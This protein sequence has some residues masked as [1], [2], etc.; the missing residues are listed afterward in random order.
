[1]RNGGR[2]AARVLLWSG[3]RRQECEADVCEECG[4]F[5]GPTAPT[6]TGSEPGTGDAWRRIVLTLAVLVPVLTRGSQPWRERT[7]GADA[8]RERPQVQPFGRSLAIVAHPRRPVVLA[9]L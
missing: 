6:M 7:V 3:L 2:P 4:L 9:L 5:A 1:M 8:Y